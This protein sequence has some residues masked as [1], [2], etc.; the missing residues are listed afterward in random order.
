MCVRLANGTQFYANTIE[1]ADLLVRQFTSSA[2]AMTSSHAVSAEDDA[3]KL[4]DCCEEAFLVG[5][6][7]PPRPTPPPG[8]VVR[9][10]VGSAGSGD[11]TSGHNS[12]IDHIPDIESEIG[13]LDTVFEKLQEMKE[14]IAAQ[15]TIEEE[16]EQ[17][18]DEVMEVDAEEIHKI[19][20]RA[21]KLACTDEEIGDAR[22]FNGI[23]L[24]RQ[25]ALLVKLWPSLAL[26]LCDG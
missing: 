19:V 15:K 3:C 5:P 23:G 20:R 16:E 7:S 14:V 21:R 18:A 8:K 12:E 6:G 17:E 13:N 2:T 11:T 24:E 26:P 22:D 4:T 25:R 1:V 9:G 10:P